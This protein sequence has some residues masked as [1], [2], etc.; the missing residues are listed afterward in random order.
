[1][2]FLLM[3]IVVGAALFLNLF[4]PSPETNSNKTE[5]DVEKSS[6]GLSKLKHKIQTMPFSGLS[7]K[8]SNSTLY[9]DHHIGLDDFKVDIDLLV[10]NTSSNRMK[11][12][13]NIIV[14][15]III[16]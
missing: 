5:E 2:W 12:H 13:S 1:M 6:P 7:T 4:F 14:Y 16:D 8:T 9:F 11:H 15:S 3:T 10:E